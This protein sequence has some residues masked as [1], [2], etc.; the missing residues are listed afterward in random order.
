MAAAGRKLGDA[1]I[2]VT[3]D[4]RGIARDLSAEA[5]KELDAAAATMGETLDERL[6][7]SVERSTDGL[8]DTLGDELDKGAKRSGGKF[9]ETLR[10]SLTKAVADLPDLTIDVD[11]S[12]ADHTINDVRR[13]LEE[14]AGK[15]IGVDIDAGAALSEVAIIDAE[16]ARLAAQTVDVQVHTDTAAARASLSALSAQMRR[17]DGDDVDVDVN[18]GGAAATSA[19][20]SVLSGLRE[21][22]PVA[23]GAAGVFKGLLIPAIIGGVLVLGA[24]GPAAVAGLGVVAAMAVSAA[25]GMGVLMLGISGVADAMKLLTRKEDALATAVGGGGA[26]AAAAEGA[27]RSLANARENAADAAVRAAERITRAQ[28]D[29]AVTEAETAR[30]T[31]DALRG[32]EDA[33][34]GVIKAIEEARRQQED[35]ANDVAGNALSQRQAVLDVTDAQKELNKVLRNRRATDAMRENAQ[36]AYDSAIQRQAELR[37][38]GQRLAAE[39]EDASVKGV[40]G[41]DNVVEAQQRLIDA[42]QDYTDAQVEGARSVL[43]AQR[44]VTDAIKEQERQARQSAYAI[45]SALAAVSGASAGAG[46][47][48]SGLAEI[49]RELAK[50]NPATLTFAQFMNDRVM[51]AIERVKGAAAA[52]LLPGVQAGLEALEP[53]LPRFESIV[54]TIGTKLGDLFTQAGERLNSPFWLSFFDDLEVKSG[55]ILQDLADAAWNV[56]EGIAGIVQAFLGLADDETGFDLAGATQDFADWGKS[57]KDNPDFKEFIDGVK[58]DFPKIVQSTKDILGAFKDLAV[59]FDENSDTILGVLNGVT[60]FL[61]WEPPDWLNPD[62]YTKKGEE[63]RDAIV[64]WFNGVK[65]WW[66]GIDWGEFGSNILDG[67]IQG[68]KDAVG[69]DRA[70]EQ[71]QKLVDGFKDFFGIHSPS[72]LFAEL[73]GWIIDG[74]LQGLVD[75]VESVLTWFRDLPGKIGTALSNLGTVIGDKASSAF[76]WFKDTATSKAGELVEWVRGLPGKL[77]S[78]IGD[79]GSLLYNKGRDLMQGL[80]NGISA[81]ASFVGNTAK[82]IVNAVIGFI[83][84]KVIGGINSLLE[85]KVMGVTINPPDIP[86][87]PLLANGAIVDRPTLAVVGEAG[88]EAVIPLSAGRAGRRAALMEEA[89]LTG[90]G[91]TVDARQYYEVRDT[92]TAQEVGAVVGQRIVRDLRNGV[93]GRYGTGAA[94]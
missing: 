84:D 12:Y 72:T 14:L 90:A 2:A 86:R 9:Q 60:D 6:K 44:A 29:L 59:W 57:L 77:A 52:G 73:G 15:T 26:S 51:P 78:A 45:A 94:A 85:F 42:Q 7:E 32:V 11:S 83:N 46:G 66:N 34:R 75:T 37:L 16:L 8:G 56:V 68:L 80:V 21:I 63:T 35:L 27:A 22:G 49:N 81:A 54:G 38:Q 18:V 82:T 4:A 41:A 74:L 89:G 91:L 53:L 33:Q 30:R 70:V 58:E 71:W 43:T 20:Q 67:I 47:G 36:L 13:R 50:V 10:K 17:L 55:P 48:A 39:Q 5:S 24:M 19:L 93:S 1:Y 28:E 88:P 25:A 79:L 87:I 76:Q 3:A 65:D 23:T 31:A 92:Q 69:W 40:E 62:W 64:G 61:D